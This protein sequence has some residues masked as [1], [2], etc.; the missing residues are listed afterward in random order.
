MN[1]YDYIDDYKAGLLSGNALDE[2]ET[3]MASDEKLRRLVEQYDEIKSVSEGVLEL[4]LLNEL[5]GIQQDFVEPEKKKKTRT[6]YMM[7]ATI[8]LCLAAAACYLFFYYSGQKKEEP[9]LFADVYHEPI[10][11]VTKSIAKE[12]NDK[13]YIAKAS[14]TY[15]SGDF[16]VAK[17]ILLDSVQD[18]AMA[19]YWLAE[20]YMAE[21]EFDSVLVYLPEPTE[22]KNKGNRISTLRQWIKKLRDS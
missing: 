11:P 18:Q 6:D 8:L 16:V 15:L 10:W 2:F 20:M 19:H 4:Q 14:A 13:H 3:A 9:L 12:R 5:T 7:L 1:A 17:T 22:I 21:Q